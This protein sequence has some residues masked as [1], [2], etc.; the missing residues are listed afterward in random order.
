MLLN[1]SVIIFL[2]AIL[3]WHDTNRRELKKE[4]IPSLKGANGWINTKPL[5]LGDLHGKVVLIDFW[6]YSC[7]NWRRTLPYLREWAAK[8]K[9]QGLV[10]IGIHTPEFSFERSIENVSRSVIEMGISYPVAL[11]NNFDIWR[12]FKNQY[13]PALYLIDATGKIR[14]QKFGE[15]DYQE[16]ELQIRKLL[17]KDLVGETVSATST[18]PPQPD[19]YETAADWDHLRSPETYLGYNRSDGFASPQLMIA[20]EPILYSLPWR[21]ELNQWALSGEW[22]V[23]EEGNV[24][25]R[26]KGKITY[27]FHARDLHLV[28]GSGKG[29]MPL[30][31]RI[32][33]DGHPPGPDH[34]LDVDKDGNGTLTLPRMYQL[35]RQIGTVVDREF[36]IEF[37][38]S[39]VDVYV[40]TFG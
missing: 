39:N 35:V 40:F 8:Y 21:L 13:W 15:G 24:M 32:L 14:F 26:K 10:V 28:M 5:A 25:T 36:Q 1:I 12:S 33:I 31:F 38:D 22:V 3:G 37:L 29:E 27:R 30:K 20:N 18:H 9:D 23:G 7:I 17:S 19:G 4:M 11:D 2:A 34:G 16:C 6:T